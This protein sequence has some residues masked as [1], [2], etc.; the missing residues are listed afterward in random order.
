VKR[1]GRLSENRE[2][3]KFRLRQVWLISAG[4]ELHTCGM[5]KCSEIGVK[6]NK[7]RNTKVKGGTTPTSGNSAR[8]P[9]EEVLSKGG[10]KKAK[11]R[12]GETSANKGTEKK[13][14][15]EAIAEKNR[16]HSIKKTR[17]KGLGSVPWISPMPLE[18]RESYL[19]KSFHTRKYQRREK[20]KTF[21]RK[22]RGPGQSNRRRCRRQGISRGRV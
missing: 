11:P 7:K 22:S 14:H 4:S 8:A 6:T 1:K 5:L 12:R 9:G 21:V 15:Q 3:S 17:G 2:L 13:R 20:G 18:K 10:K 19:G 16:G